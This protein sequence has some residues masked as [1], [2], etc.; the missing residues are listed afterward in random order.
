VVPVVGGVGDVGAVV[1]VVEGAVVVRVV[2]GTVVKG[3]VV[4][5][6][7]SVAV[8]SVGSVT[9]VSAAVL[10]VAVAPSSV[11]D[12]YTKRQIGEKGNI[13][14][15]YLH[16]IGKLGDPKLEQLHLQCRSR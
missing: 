13:A 12:A 11:E 4:V 14:R 7:V 16:H 3:V 1:L 5:T 2:E 10:S 9:V 8:L 6:V 15:T